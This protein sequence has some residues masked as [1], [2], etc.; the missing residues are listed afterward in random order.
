MMCICFDSNLPY[1]G[2]IRPILKPRA[3][4][5]L[6]LYYSL[7]WHQA[8]RRSIGPGTIIIAWTATISL[9][10]AC[11][12]RQRRVFCWINDRT[13]FYLRRYSNDEIVRFWITP[14]LCVQPGSNSKKSNLFSVAKNAATKCVPN[15]ECISS[16]LV[17]LLGCLS[18]ML[19]NSIR[20]GCKRRAKSLRSI[21]T[22]ALSES[23]LRFWNS[24]RNT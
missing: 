1:D 23:S 20:S 7:T 21:R 4:H 18:R 3:D 13:D 16:S 14:Y 17:V 8:R 22:S 6:Y 15:P 11:I 2:S 24:K 9:V 12:I 10:G 19:R 5:C